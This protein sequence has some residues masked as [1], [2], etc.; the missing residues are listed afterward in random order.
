[1]CN[2][3][4]FWNEGFRGFGGLT[5]GFVGDSV[6]FG[7][8][9][10]GVDDRGGKGVGGRGGPGGRGVLRLATLAQDDGHRERLW[11]P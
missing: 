6:G 10:G 3:F 11:L 1:M 8:H 2:D 7:H 4:S 9:R 5:R